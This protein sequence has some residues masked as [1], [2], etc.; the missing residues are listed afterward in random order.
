MRDD[1]KVVIDLRYFK[2]LLFSEV[3]HIDKKFRSKIEDD[4]KI[5]SQD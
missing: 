1:L 2:K 3:H 5:V 4:R